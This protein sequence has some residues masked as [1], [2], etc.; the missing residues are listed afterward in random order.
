MVNCTVRSTRW[1]PS[2]RHAI[3]CN[4]VV[5]HVFPRACPLPHATILQLPDISWSPSSAGHS[6]PSSALQTVPK[7][8]R[9]PSSRAPNKTWKLTK[10][11]SPPVAARRGRRRRRAQVWSLP[12]PLRSCTSAAPGPAAVCLLSSAAVLGLGRG[13]TTAAPGCPA[14]APGR[15]ALGGAAHGSR[16]CRTCRR[17]CWTTA[18]MA[19][20]DHKS[21][22]LPTV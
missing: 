6:F 8:L 2:E 21:Q 13:W 14:A 17:R 16:G 9:P 1:R 10:L 18:P 15:A 5:K 12:Q 11:P 22:S 19:Q 4:M 20:P 3:I 7:R